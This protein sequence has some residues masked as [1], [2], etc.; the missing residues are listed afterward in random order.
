MQETFTNIYADF[1]QNTLNKKIKKTQDIHELKVRNKES[2]VINIYT[3]NGR[4]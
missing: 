4:P 3:P 1:K 2:E